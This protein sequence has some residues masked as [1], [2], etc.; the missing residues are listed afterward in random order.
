MKLND[1]EPLQTFELDGQTYLQE[2]PIDRTKY[3]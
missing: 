2:T 3:V 1:L